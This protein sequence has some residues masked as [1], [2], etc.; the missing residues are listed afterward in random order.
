MRRIAISLLAGC[1]LLT[2]LPPQLAHAAGEVAVLPTVTTPGK[3]ITIKWYFTGEKVLISGGRFGK[4]TVVTGKNSVT[5]TPQA[6]TRY[7][8]DVWY[9][10]PVAAASPA[11]NVLSGVAKGPGSK[12]IQIPSVTLPAPGSMF[13]AKA[14]A[15]GTPTGVMPVATVPTPQPKEGGS[16]AIH[17][18][19]VILP[20]PGSVVPVKSPSPTASAAV[21]SPASHGNTPPAVVPTAPPAVQAP[22]TA[23]P[24]GSP[25]VPNGGVQAPPTA[26]AFTLQHVQY[27]TY[28]EVWSGIYPAMNSYRDSHGWQ[29]NFLSGWK[30]DN[31]P[32]AAEGSDGLVYFQQEDDSVE[33]L[34]VAI[35]PSKEMT[36]DDLMKKVNTDVDNHYL[37]ATLT[38][39]VDI[40]LHSVP[41]KMTTFTGLDMSHPGT[42]T[43]SVVVLFVR[44]GKA[45][46]ISA[47]SNATHFNGRRPILEKMALSFAFSK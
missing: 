44:N 36:L 41:A 30:R 11:P 35:M 7:T 4:G 9:R 45:Y 28:A 34:A 23:L 5:D 6:T 3:P 25:A 27:T 33:R 43:S 40:T 21:P 19:E 47:R 29:V 20:S 8:F 10:V 17:I 31:V 12:A 38:E 32:T 13:P 16:K 18:Q 39:P 1:A 14:P 15:Q 42:Q 26:P 22:G 2:T 24:A 46:V 37:K